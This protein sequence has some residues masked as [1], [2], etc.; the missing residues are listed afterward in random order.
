M[1]R[2]AWAQ[3]SPRQ[4]EKYQTPQLHVHYLGR[5]WCHL[6]SMTLGSP[7]VHCYLRR[8]WLLF[9]DSSIW[10]LNDFSVKVLCV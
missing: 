1:E 9:L 8:R 3:I 4:N 10:C 2:K 6:G 7:T 5:W